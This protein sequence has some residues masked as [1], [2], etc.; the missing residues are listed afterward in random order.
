MLACYKRR[1]FCSI[2]IQ[3]IVCQKMCRSRTEHL[4]I[5]MH[6]KKKD[7]T[8]IYQFSGFILAYFSTLYTYMHCSRLIYLKTC[9]NTGKYHTNIADEIFS[10]NKNKYDL[11][12]QTMYTFLVLSVLTDFRLWL[13][14][15]PLFLC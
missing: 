1:T 7:N 5:Q 15:I 4:C 8:I 13:D 10:T 6:N 11:S 9:Q 3:C 12:A 14:G 2:C